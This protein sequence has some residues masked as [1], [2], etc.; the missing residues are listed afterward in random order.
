MPYIG[1]EPARVPVTAADIP[2]NSITAAKIIDGAITIADIAN[3]AVTADKLA[4]SINTAIAANTAKT[5]ITSGQAGEITANT[6]KVTN[7]ITT[8][9]GEVTGGTALTIADDAVTA[10]KLA[11]SINTDIATGVTGNTTANAALPKAG[12][13]MTGDLIINGVAAPSA[14]AYLNI[15]SAGS[16][17]TRAIDIDGGWSGGE[18][19]SINFTH[20]A[21]ADAKVASIKATYHG[22]NATLS[23]GDLY[24]GANSSTA[25]LS[26]TSTSTTRADLTL[27]GEF[28]CKS[29][30]MTEQPSFLVG[31]A[32]ATQATNGHHKLNNMTVERFDTAGNYTNAEFTAPVTGRYQFNWTIRVDGLSS[33]SAHSSVDLYTSNRHFTYST[34]NDMRSLDQNPAYWSFC[35]SQL[36]DMDLGDK[37]YL[38]SY[39][40]STTGTI[41]S[42]SNWSG[43]L[44]A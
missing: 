42:Q 41:E 18:S 8:H 17:E 43:Y 23:L 25:T 28:N 15:G 36:V 20:G 32:N 9:T 2:D 10:A 30:R 13:A 38:T 3:D 14:L 22:P 33:T 11:N 7:A 12:G 40:H 44:V 24:Y 37:A 1:K 35:G 5:G 29:L 6:A 4:N 27:E 26:L 31:C 16:G 21:T 34:I 39:F 19:K